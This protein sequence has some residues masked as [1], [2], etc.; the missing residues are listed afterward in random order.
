MFKKLIAIAALAVSVTFVGCE[1]K[2]APVNL[3]V[4]GGY[5]WAP[6]VVQKHQDASSDYAQKDR[7][8]VN[9]AIGTEVGATNVQLEY[10]QVKPNTAGPLS[11]SAKQETTALVAQVPVLAKGKASLYGIG[12]LGY[13]RLTAANH[14][15]NDGL[16]GIVGVGT[17]YKLNPT[18]SLLAEGR[19][20]WVEFDNYWQPQ[21]LVGVRV[22]MDQV[23][24]NIQGK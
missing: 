20:Q 7:G 21:A 11:Q 24:K 22:S 19:A 1:A 5:Q 9:A 16:V 15:T 13:T 8:F 23:L 18:V 3:S 4:L 14:P 2:A 12:G 10:S 17:E 6:D